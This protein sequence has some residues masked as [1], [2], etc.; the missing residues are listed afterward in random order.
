MIILT[1]TLSSKRSHIQKKPSR[2]ISLTY[3]S[4]SDKQKNPNLWFRNWG[5]GYPCRK[6]VAE[7]EHNENFW[8]GGKF[9]V[10]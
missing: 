4:K 9:L 6:A 1:N 7:R 8:G 5:S 10:S 2:M 3:S